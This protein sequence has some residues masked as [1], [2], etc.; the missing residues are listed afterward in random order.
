MTNGRHQMQVTTPARM[1][2]T[3]AAAPG[4]SAAATA[5]T[6]TAA[7][8]TATELLATLNQGGEERGQGFTSNGWKDQV[9]IPI[10]VPGGTLEPFRLSVI[11]CPC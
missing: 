5:A 3:T 7:P 8:E 4:T 6:T 1:P 9:Q 2:K 10:Q 11:R